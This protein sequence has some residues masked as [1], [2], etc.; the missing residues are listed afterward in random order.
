MARETQE[1]QHLSEPLSGEDAER[2]VAYIEDPVAPAGHNEYL[3]QA[4][5]VHSQIKP[6][7]DADS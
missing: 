2:L 4:D 5:E 6:R 3:K 7:A 1:Q